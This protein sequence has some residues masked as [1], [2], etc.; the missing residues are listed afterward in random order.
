MTQQQ[1]KFI[2]A[3]QLLDRTVSY[4]FR[5]WTVV[6]ETNRT[7]R[8]LVAKIQVNMSNKTQ[9]SKLFFIISKIGII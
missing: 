6:N 1:K 4:A 8:N 2:L 7:Y 5:S 3:Y 9:N